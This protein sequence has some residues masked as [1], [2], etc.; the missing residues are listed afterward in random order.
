MPDNF[1]A[2]LP[3]FYGWI[4]VA[5]AFVTV[6]LGV[7]AR[8]AFS[9]MFPPIVA[10]FG[11]ERGLAAGAFSF[12]FLVS[13]LCSPIVG[14]L[15]DRR[16]PRFVIEAGV[17]IMAAGLLGA[18][19]IETP[20][21][22]YLT[23]GVLVGVGANCM[24]FTAQSQYLPNWFIR[25]RALAISIAFAGAGA[26]AIVLLPW[27]QTIIS[28]DGWRASCA[29]LGIIALVVLV[30]INLLVRKRPSEVGLHPDGDR[31]GDGHGV[32][33][34][35]SNVV[36]PS[37]VA[38]D[39]TLRRAMRTGR[40]WWI[41]VGYFCAGFVWYAVQVHQTKY[42]VEIGFSTMQAAWALGLVA[43]VAVPGQIVLG[44]LSDRIGR[45]I[46]WSITCA[47]FAICYA[48]LLA[49]AD[50]PSQGLLYIMILS[51]GV[52]G[53]GL[54]ALMGPIA[55]EI[56]EGPHFGSIFGVITVALVGGGA[57]GPLVAGVIHDVTGSYNVAFALS[58]VLCVVS[59][60]AIWRA[61]PSRVR[62]VAGRLQP[63]LST[64]VAGD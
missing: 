3:F 48:A 21:Q 32:S 15:M 54:T 6:A 2:R 27:L 30:P 62:L 40:F 8:T 13:A 23:L 51:Q 12:G 53:Y 9:L 18:T 33:R 11:W 22:L 56:F 64:K 55:V 25:R 39:W 7:T 57:V 31:T 26:G 17:L 58:I 35:V 60:G 29:T 20:W 43:A 36:D 1:Q 34:G 19:R 49:L 37:W 42:L 10:E 59:A 24:T 16:G 41:V 38:I 5:V 44:A 14:R 28:R 61:S 4:I 47:G 46:V 52:L 45:E 63:R 50:G